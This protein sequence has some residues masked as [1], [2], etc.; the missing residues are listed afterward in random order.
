MWKLLRHASLTYAAGNVGAVVNSL[1]A[2]L[3]GMLGVSAALG[4]KMAPALTAGWL[5]PRLVWGGLWGL[6]FS[7]PFLP[8]SPLLRGFLFSIGPTFGQLFIVF[9]FSLGKGMLG[10]DLGTLTPVLVILFNAIW[11]IVTSYWLELTQDK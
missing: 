4:V 1:A 5:Y 8:G 7:L 2:W 10:L 6:L 9:P 3:F 11:G